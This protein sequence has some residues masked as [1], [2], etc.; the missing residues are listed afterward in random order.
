MAILDRFDTPGR[1]GE[2][3]E[4]DR[5]SWSSRVAGMFDGLTPDFPQF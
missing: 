3:S 1:L 4:D 5:R 2:L